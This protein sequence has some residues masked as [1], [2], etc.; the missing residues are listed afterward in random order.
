MCDLTLKGSF[1]FARQ[2]TLNT[3]LHFSIQANTGCTDSF[4]IDDREKDFEPEG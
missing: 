2:I 1:T 4:I 3:P